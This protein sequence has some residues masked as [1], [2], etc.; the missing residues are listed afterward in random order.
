M[1]L[2]KESYWNILGRQVPTY[3]SRIKSFGHCRSLPFW[4][5]FF[6]SLQNPDDFTLWNFNVMFDFQTS[7]EASFEDGPWCLSSKS[8][9]TFCWKLNREREIKEVTSRRK[10]KQS[11][12]FRSRESTFAPGAFY[13]IFYIYFIYSTLFSRCIWYI[14]YYF[15]IYS[16]YSILFLN[17]FFLHLSIP[18]S[19][20][21]FISKLYWILG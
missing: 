10:Q 3:G 13:T 9:R 20:N 8:S 12:S 1:D 7:S 18:F 16:I 5:Y 19:P 17:I 4:I 14:L 15:Y 21:N 11:K 2:L 6:H